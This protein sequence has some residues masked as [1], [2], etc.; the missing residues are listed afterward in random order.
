MRAHA[1]FQW[2]MHLPTLAGRAQEANPTPCSNAFHKQHNQALPY[3]VTQHQVKLFSIHHNCLPFLHLLISRHAWR[4]WDFILYLP[5]QRKVSHSTAHQNRDP[6][7]LKNLSEGDFLLLFF[8]AETK[9]QMPH[10]FWHT[11]LTKLGN[12]VQSK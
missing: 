4:D 9:K 10:V 2:S 7:K 11:V 6:Q 5:Q 1:V 12:G 8:H 3:Q